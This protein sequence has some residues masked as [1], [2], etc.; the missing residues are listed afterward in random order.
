MRVTQS[1][2]WPRD[3]DGLHV[4]SVDSQSISFFSSHSRGMD[5]TKAGKNEPWVD[6]IYI[7]QQNDLLCSS[8]DTDDN[9]MHPERV[10]QSFPQ[11]GTILSSVLGIQRPIRHF[12]PQSDFVKRVDMPT[13][14]FR[15]ERSELRGSRIIL[16]SYK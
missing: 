2:Y 16:K 3:K 4:E 6:Y 1:T 10:A 7:D 11:S 15:A 14:T 9:W 8:Y 5:N 13:S 12:S